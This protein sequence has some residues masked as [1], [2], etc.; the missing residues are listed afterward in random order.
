MSQLLVRN[1]HEEVVE[2]LK[3]RAKANHRSLQAELA[4]ILENAAKIQPTNFWN[5]SAKIREQFAK[6]KQSF[7]DSA[8]LVREDR[9]SEQ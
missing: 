4:L 3:H 7:A 9:D 5:N 6:S 2:S 1:L 8:E